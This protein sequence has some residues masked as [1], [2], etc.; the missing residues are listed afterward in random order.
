MFDR[1]RLDRIRLGR[2][3]V[4]GLEFVFAVVSWQHLSR[5]GNAKRRGA[6]YPEQPSYTIALQPP[7]NL[8]L[9]FT[10]LRRALAPTS[11]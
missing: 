2:V 10:Q 1:I 3:R 6:G 8:L 5:D 7:A 4:G 11:P 9:P